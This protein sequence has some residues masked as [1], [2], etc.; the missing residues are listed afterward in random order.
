[1]GKTLVQGGTVVTAIEQ[2]DADVLID[3]GEVA[4]LLGRNTPLQPTK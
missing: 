4:A 2:M 1:M 3:V